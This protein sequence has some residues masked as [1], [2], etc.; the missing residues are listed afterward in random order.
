MI[1]TKIL[2]LSDVSEEKQNAIRMDIKKYL[3]GEGQM[4]D[5]SVKHDATTWIT[6]KLLR[7]EIGFNTKHNQL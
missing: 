2:K 1:K 5:I 6:Q 7:L 3:K 4:R